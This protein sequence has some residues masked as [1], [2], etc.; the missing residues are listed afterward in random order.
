MPYNSSES[1]KEKACQSTFR[2]YHLLI[3]VLPLHLED[4]LDNEYIQ[5]TSKMSDD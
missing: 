3:D 4:V 2:K 5:G 1:I